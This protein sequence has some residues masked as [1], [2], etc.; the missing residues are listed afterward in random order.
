MK[1]AKKKLTIYLSPKTNSVQEL[2]K[3]SKMNPYLCLTVK[4]SKPISYV[5]KHLETK[6]SSILDENKM[7]K[8]YPKTVNFAT[9]QHK[10]WSSK[11][12]EIFLT[13]ISESKESIQLEYSFEKIKKSPQKVI[14]ENSFPLPNIN[15]LIPKTPMKSTNFK[16]NS[17]INTTP[18]SHFS[19][20]SNL[21]D[22]TEIFN[23]LWKQEE[24]KSLSFLSSPY[25]KRKFES[26]ESSDEKSKKQ[27]IE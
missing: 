26:E 1:T 5:V 16:S 12:D 9:G 19:G 24:E 20:N 25:F 2:I 27:K 3:K 6:W 4:Y 18:S 15:S 23:N 22:S 21:D 13:E 17:S 10:G 7:I 11:E 8:I 14:H